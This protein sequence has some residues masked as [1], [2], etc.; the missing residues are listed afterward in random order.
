[1]EVVPMKSQ[2]QASF[3]GACLMGLGVGLATFSSTVSAGATFQNIAGT[4]C[5]AFNNA[6]A[7]ALERSHVRLY[8]PP[9]SGRNLWVVCQMQRVLEDITAPNFTVSAF[10]GAE[11]ASGTGVNCIFREFSFQTDHEPGDGKD[12]SD[13]YILNVISV[14]LTKVG[15]DAQVQSDGASF[16]DSGTQR[17]WTWT[18]LLP[19]GSG[20]NSIDVQTG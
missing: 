19:P 11:A 14:T 4:A 2:S 8:N 5:G 6:Q 16:A 20:I 17:F 9:T 12:T 18:C 10:F 13:P 3:L 7:N 15:T 1:M